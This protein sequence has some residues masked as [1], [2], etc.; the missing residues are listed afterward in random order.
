[1]K[2]ADAAQQLNNKTL[3]DAGKKLFYSNKLKY[4]IIYICIAQIGLLLLLGLTILIPAEA[5]K[6]SACDCVKMNE[7]LGKKVA[8]PGA[9][10]AALTKEATDLAEKCKDV[11]LADA[12]DCK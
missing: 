11:N 9:D 8:A 2:I 1:M 12:K 5:G 3:H 6:P 4:S 7:E 10:Q